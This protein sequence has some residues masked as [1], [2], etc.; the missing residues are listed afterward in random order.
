MPRKTC[1][2]ELKKH[3]IGKNNKEL[4]ET[5]Q[6]LYRMN[7]ENQRFLESRFFEDKKEIIKEYK[8][9]IRSCLYPDLM[10]GEEI[11][12]EKAEKAIS[13]YRKA[14]NDNLGILELMICFLEYGNNFTCDFGDIDEE[15]YDSLCAM[16][17][18]ILTELKKHESNIR[19]K[20]LPRLISIRD[21]ANGIGWGYYDYL[22]EKISEIIE[23][24]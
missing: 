15:F 18:S 4:I 17:D 5:I 20:F 19:K 9:L 6:D 8:K 1:W 16:L 23:D 22:N 14:I 24:I 11:N 7:D 13:Q 12:F 2:N 10:H 21:S 3:L